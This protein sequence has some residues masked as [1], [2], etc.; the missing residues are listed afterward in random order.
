MKARGERIVMVTTYDAPSA[1]L[2]E[3]AGIDVLLVGDTA[4]MVVFGHESTLPVTLDEMLMLTRAVTRV[5]RRAAGRRGPAVR[6]VPGVGR[7]GGRERGAAGEGRRRGRRQAGR[8]RTAPLAR[9]RHHRGRHSGHGPYRP[10]AAGGDHARR[11]QDA[12]PHGSRSA[13][14]LRHRARAAVGGL[15]RDR[16]RSHAGRR[17]HR[18]HAGPVD[19]DDRHRRRG[20]LRWPGARLARSARAVASRRFRAS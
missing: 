4:A 5:A 17:G 9:A 13:A 19:S 2:A 11:V 8:D 18:D 7:R 10:D 3:A 16:A 12:G 6:V 14:A 15:L 1:R 20:R